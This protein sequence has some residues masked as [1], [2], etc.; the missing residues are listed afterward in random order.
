MNYGHIKPKESSNCVSTLSK[1]PEKYEFLK[2]RS[3][4]NPN[5]F[6][7]I[8]LN[9][10]DQPFWPRKT[11][12][13][14]VH[15]D[16]IPFPQMVPTVIDK[17]DEDL[18]VMQQ[19]SDK[20][21]EGYPHMGMAAIREGDIPDIVHPY[22]ESRT[23]SRVWNESGKVAIPLPSV[24]EKPISVNEY[25]CMLLQTEIPKL[26]SVHGTALFKST[27]FITKSPPIFH[28]RATVVDPE[29]NCNPRSQK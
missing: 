7:H 12:R 20:R 18:R 5:S 15:Y 2:Q 10:R 14:K 28:Q 13:I 6:N 1:I 23:L 27:D 21:R 22:Y 4:R 8:K 9:K 17:P 16:A 25:N 19:E 11:S 24:L 3:R 29:T 26:P